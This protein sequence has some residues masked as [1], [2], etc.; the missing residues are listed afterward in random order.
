MGGNGNCFLGINGNGIEVSEFQRQRM[1][2]GI[3]SWEWEGMG[4]QKLFPHISTLVHS[5]L[6]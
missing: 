2:M 5:R 4:C 1:G 3:K 6:D